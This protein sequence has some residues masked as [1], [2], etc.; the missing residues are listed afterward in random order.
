MRRTFCLE[1]VLL[2]TIL[3][4]VLVSGEVAWRYMVDE[5]GEFTGPWRL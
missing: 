4:S 3:V 5:L 1:L 2:C